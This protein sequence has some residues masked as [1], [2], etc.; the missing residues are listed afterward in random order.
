MTVRRVLCAVLAAAVVAI[1]PL[2]AVSAHAADYDRADLYRADGFAREGTPGWALVD[3]ALREG[4]GVAYAVTGAV[5]PED[6]RIAVLRCAPRWCLVRKGHAHG[7]TSR[8]AVGFGRYPLGPF[9]GGGVNYASG[10]PG[11][12][13]FFEGAHYSGRSACFKSGVNIHDLKLM[14]LDNRYVSVSVEGNV[15]ASVCRDRN[16]QSYCTRIVTSTPV[17]NTFLAGKV[18]SI[19]IH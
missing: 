17:L 3:L 18:S 11:Q 1:V 13:C 10:G 12:V 14:G 7:W 16:F 8:S 6:S 19:R 2:L 4:P 9:E 15:S 5:I